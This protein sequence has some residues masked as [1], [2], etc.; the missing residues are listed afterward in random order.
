MNNASAVDR[1]GETFVTL[2]NED[3]LANFGELQFLQGAEEVGPNETVEVALSG[4]ANPLEWDG[5]SLTYKYSYEKDGENHEVWL[6]SESALSHRLQQA[7]NYNLRGISVHGLEGIAKMGQVMLRLLIV[8][9]VRPMHPSPRP[10]LLSGLFAT[11][12]TVF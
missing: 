2:S 10:Q 8:S 4:T 11:R 12:T 1:I 9:K 7:T 3:A 6:G 5:N